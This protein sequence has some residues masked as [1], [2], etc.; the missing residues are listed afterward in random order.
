MSEYNEEEYQDIYEHAAN[1]VIGTLTLEERQAF[2]TLL[3][4][5]QPARDALLYWQHRLEPLNKLSPP[6]E[7]SDFTFHRINRS[8]DV[9][10]ELSQAPKLQI[11]ETKQHSSLWRFATAALLV[12]SVGLFFHQEP[13]TTSVVVLTAP[14]QTEPGWMITSYDGEQIELK[15]LVR[16]AVPDNKA[17]EFWTK[18]DGWEKPVSL[19]L[20]DPDKNLKKQL[21]SLQGIAPNQLFE[22]TIEQ[23][24]G[25]PTGLPTGPVQFIGRAVIGI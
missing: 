11:P 21:D 19:G 13:T 9:L 10:A 16:T 6:V 23:A 1:Y 15:P 5:N 18:A 22:L 2:D 3:A 20:V 17:L 7:P 14:G 25:S 24:G 4:D 12:L 8:V